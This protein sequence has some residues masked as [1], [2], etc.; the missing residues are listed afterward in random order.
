MKLVVLNPNTN[1]GMTD[2]V[3]LGLKPH[4]PATASV[5]GLTAFHGCAVIDSRETFAMG[6][7]S[8]AQLLQDVPA[9]T[10]GILLACFGDPGLR[11]LRAATSI[12]LVGLAEAAVLQAHAQ[13]LRFAIITAGANWVAMLQECVAGYG[14]AQ[15]LVGVYALAGNGAA[16]R[17]DP[18]AFSAEV[19]RLAHQ[20]KADGAQALIL[21]GAAFAGLH[22][23]LPEGLHIID[24]L[25][26][27]AHALA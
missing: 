25:Q 13:G 15:N 23:D 19:T 21:G 22:F 11:A 4:L 7:A 9:H 14:A 16:L 20:A 1:T 10:T 17:R 5:Q 12:P 6:A 18:A 27:A 2:A 3:V 24:P 8:A 26:A